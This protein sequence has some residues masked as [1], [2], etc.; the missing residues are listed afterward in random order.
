[1]LKPLWCG[2]PKICLWSG[3]TSPQQY[4]RILFAP[5]GK[6][7]ETADEGER[8]QKYPLAKLIQWSG[9]TGVVGRKRLQK[10]VFF[11]QK[12]GCPFGADYTLHHYGPYSRDV[13]DACDE[14]VAAGILNERAEINSVGTQYTYTVSADS[15]MAAIEQTE[16]RLREQAETMTTFKSLAEELLRK[17]L[18]ELELGSTILYF[19]QKSASWEDAQRLACEF[20]GKNASN[21][22]ALPAARA[23]AMRVQ[24]C[25]T[26]T[27]PV[28]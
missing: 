18:W 20:K 2:E 14:L 23:L 12:A 8:V 22:P 28:R 15:G 6:C 3:L 26:S 16:N 7:R 27:N 24:H 25:A 1:M 11:L 13:A 4:G 9:P 10:I 21:E 17:S 19:F 5:L